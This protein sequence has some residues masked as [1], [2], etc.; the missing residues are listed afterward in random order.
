L[1]FKT[2]SLNDYKHVV[3][4]K[5]ID[6]SN[7]DDILKTNKSEAL[8]FEEK[9]GEKIEVKEEETIDKENDLNKNLEDYKEC[10]ICLEPIITGKRLHCGHINH[11]K[12]LK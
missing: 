4:N 5:K 7:I 6:E 1:I 8:D 9:S 3:I 10:S 12:C 11:L 2:F